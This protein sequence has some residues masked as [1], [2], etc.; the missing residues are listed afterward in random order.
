ME[1]N[2][3]TQSIKFESYQT[4]Q[5][6]KLFTALAKA[7]SEMNIAELNCINPFYKSKYADLSS[8]VKASREF[9]CKNGLSVIQ[10]IIHNQDGNTLLH[11]KLCHS[12]GQWLES[13]MRVVPTDTKV[14]SLGSY[15]AYL[16]RYAYASIV[17]V[18]ASDTIVNIGTEGSANSA[19]ED[20]DGE[21]DRKND[22]HGNGASQEKISKEQ[23]H[24]LEK[25]CESYDD[26]VQ[27][28]KDGLKINNL[29]DMPKEKFDGCLKYI[30]KVKQKRE[31][32]HENS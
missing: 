14:Q 29:C 15:L 26:I 32:P 19:S 18:V 25:E 23:L 28:L 2:V 7:Q 20:D 22:R 24:T 10:Q 6:D 30:L 4:E 17:G 9:L 1:N 21:E 8:I 31:V 12:S 11:T 5:L 3:N 16:R 27:M 13:R